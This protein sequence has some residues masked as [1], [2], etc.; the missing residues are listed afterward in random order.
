MAKPR[1]FVSSTYYDLKH[2][3]SS[4]EQFIESIGYEPVLFEKGDIAYMPDT[5]LDESC[6]AEAAAADIFVLIVGGRYGSEN[7]ADHQDKGH[8]FHD[9]YDSVTKKEFETAYEADVPTYILVDSAVYGEYQ[10]YLRNKENELIKYSHV[11]SPNIFRFIDYVLNKPRNNPVSNFD[12]FSQ[13]EAWLREQWS[14]LFRELLRNRSQQRQLSTLSTQIG[15][16]KAANG[17]LKNYLEEVLR[18]VEP[19]KSSQIIESEQRRFVESLTAEQLKSNG[20]YSFVMSKEVDEQLARKSII[21][22]E[23]YRD[24]EKVWKVLFHNELALE[25]LA[26]ID[27][28]GMAQDDFNR[29]RVILQRPPLNFP[30][31]NEPHDRDMRTDA[32]RRAP[33]A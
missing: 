6:Y 33:I 15:E 20:W 21:Q 1:I 7:S 25:F 14:G 26:T 5:A 28:F 4:L 18:G 23:T 19:A 29:T 27:H 31:R 30:A 8:Q 11:D 32:A 24:L 22:P 3:R 16:L 9:V 17:T 2:I 12:R 10:T 13:I